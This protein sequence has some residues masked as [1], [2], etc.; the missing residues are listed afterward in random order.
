MIQIL[1]FYLMPNSMVQ[2]VEIRMTF[3]PHFKMTKVAQMLRFY[4]KAEFNGAEG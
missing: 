3:A 2:R 4:F 1:R